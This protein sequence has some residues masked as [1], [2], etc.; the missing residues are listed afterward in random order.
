M[1]A[2]FLKELPV[3]P[4]EILNSARP[5][6]IALQHR[7][8]IKAITFEDVIRELK[9]RPL[10]EQEV[11]A[12]LSWWL[13]LHKQGAN[14]HLHAI[15]TELLNAAVLSIGKPGDKDERIIPLSIIKT[16]IN[17]R[18]LGAHI[19][20]DGP[21]PDHL[22]PPTISKPF[23][24]DQLLD[25]MPWSELTILG[26][27]QH[28][29]GPSVASGKVDYQIDVSAPWAEKVLGVIIRAWPSLSNEVKGEVV[30][31]LKQRSCIP[32]SGGLKRPEDA[33]FINANIF[34]D[35]PVV[36]FPSGLAVKGITEK[37]LVAL[38]V[39][40]HVELQLIFNR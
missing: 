1:F 31:L 40:K 35:L 8:L 13:S 6:V 16:L 18:G 36:T 26:W 5:M 29:C 17:P 12:C 22:L 21:L 32:T 7:N 30:N 28:I 34:N 9:A 20:L 24:V 2:A 15:R 25:A 27:L 10:S 23:Q 37:V 19:P 33:Y 4:P 14:A 38:G 11:V 39:R 3:V